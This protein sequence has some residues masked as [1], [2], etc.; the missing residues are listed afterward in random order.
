MLEKPQFQQTGR[1]LVRS[2]SIRTAPSSKTP[3][4]IAKTTA[5]RIK[6]LPVRR[7]ISFTTPLDAVG[8]VAVSGRARDFPRR[9]HLFSGL[10]WGRTDKL[11]GVVVGDQSATPARI[12]ERGSRVVGN[13]YRLRRATCAVTE[14]ISPQH[15]LT[16]PDEA[17][18]T[19]LKLYRE[20][21][22]DMLTVEWSHTKLSI[23]AV[24]LEERGELVTDLAF[25][26]RA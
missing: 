17:V 3:T 1:P 23:F 25:T 15:I 22:H 12:R 14:G 20:N 16:I 19:V 26:K 2:A 13:C 18:I 21:G 6:G 4:R 8:G 24:D 9:R 5:S 11:D 10:L 7:F